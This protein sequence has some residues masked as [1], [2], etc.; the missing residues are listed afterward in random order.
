MVR[1]ALGIRGIAG[2]IAQCRYAKGLAENSPKF[3]R[4]RANKDQAFLRLKQAI[5]RDAERPFLFLFQS[6]A[7]EMRL[8]RHD[9][10]QERRFDQLSLTRPLAVI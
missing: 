8:R 6:L 10:L 1:N 7:V 2:I 5:R 3:I 4:R 9:G